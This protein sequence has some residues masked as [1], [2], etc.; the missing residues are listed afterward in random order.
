MFFLVVF[1]GL[2]FHRYPD[3]FLA[4]NRI[5][6]V[7]ALYHRYSY[8]C[9]SKETAFIVRFNRLPP[10]ADIR[11]NPLSSMPDQCALAVT[12]DYSAHRSDNRF[13]F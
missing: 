4:K 6:W 8:I 10:D 3:G 13:E 11:Y 7:L 5:S 1:F 12:A 2:D 9:N